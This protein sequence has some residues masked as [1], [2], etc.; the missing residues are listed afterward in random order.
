MD[1]L[2]LFQGLQEAAGGARGGSSLM[3]MRRVGV[4]SRGDPRERL[5]PQQSLQ[6]TDG[7][8]WGE[9]LDHLQTAQQLGLALNCSK[10]G[11][12]VACEHNGLHLL[13]APFIALS[14]R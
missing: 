2:F 1:L 5:P 4:L 11:Q 3:D 6:D 10:G 7:D 14:Y 8:Q 13:H 9:G 12:G